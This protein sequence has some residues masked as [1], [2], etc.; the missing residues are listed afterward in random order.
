MCRA[1]NPGHTVSAVSG[2]RIPLWPFYF[3]GAKLGLKMSSTG[4][5]CG[6]ETRRLHLAP[7]VNPILYE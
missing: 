1:R 6:F 4:Y 3:R 2:V 5:F 7:G